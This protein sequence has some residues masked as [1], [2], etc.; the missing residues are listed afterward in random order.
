MMD[1]SVMWFGFQSQQ[2]GLAFGE[3]RFRKYG[4]WLN[5]YNA[6]ANIA[7]VSDSLYGTRR[8]VDV[9]PVEREMSIDHAERMRQHLISQF[10][11][12]VI[13]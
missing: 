1:Y 2:Y 12:E 8:V 5:Y 11:W 7:D 4:E 3:G 6:K 13:A 9:Q 10:Q